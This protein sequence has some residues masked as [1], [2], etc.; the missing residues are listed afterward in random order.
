MDVMGALGLG[1]RRSLPIAQE[2]KSHPAFSKTGSDLR[3]H[4][5]GVGVL[6]FVRAGGCVEEG[7]TE[8]EGG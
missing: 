4:L 5:H 1:F 7:G 2:K 3:E 8:V 6:V